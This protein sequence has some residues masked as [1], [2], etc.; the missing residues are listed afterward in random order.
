MKSTQALIHW[1]EVGAGARRIRLAALLLGTL[2]LS[3][4]VAWK[5]FHGATAETTML[6]ADVGRQ[7]ARGEGFTTQVNYPQAYRVLAERGPTFDARQPR[8]ELYQAPFYSLVIAGGLRL[9]PA[10]LR[11]S[12]F[13]HAPVP[14]D[15]FAGDYFLLALNLALFWVAAWQTYDLGRRLFEPRVGWLAA[16]G[17]LLSVPL[18]QQVVAINGVPLLMVLVLAVFRCWWQVEQAAETGAV[19]PWGWLAGLGVG[20]GLLFLTEYSAG[21]LVL[22]VLGYV[23]WRWRQGGCWAALGMVALA[24]LLVA[25]PWMARNLELTGNPVALA[26]QNLA[27]KA[28]DPTASPETVRA[29][30]SAQRPEVDLN[31]LGNKVLTS[32]QQNLVARLWGGGAMWFMAFFAV[33]WLYAFRTSATDRMRWLFTLSLLVLLI[34]QAAANSG[35]SER[36]PAIYLAPLIIIFGAGFFFVLVGSNPRLAAWPRVFATLLLALQ[37]LPL[38]HDVMEPRRLHFDYPPYYPGLFVGMR[39]ELTRRD[40]AQR[41]GVMADVPAGVAWY[42]DQ[43]VWAQPATLRDFYAITLDQS[44]GELLLTPHTL[45]RPF[46]S[47]LA[48]ARDDSLATNNVGLRRFGDWG[49]VYA[50]LA[51]GRLPDGF[52]LRVPQRLAENLYVLINPALPPPR[53]K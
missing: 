17:V 43:G 3:V 44:I 36:L 28:G 14:P 1:L 2:A 53:G 27:L 6:Q 37:A 42:G 38:L 11:A 21:A 10:R 39:E 34:V 47:E 50:G 25:G 48:S 19:R 26:A 15:G 52:P 35:E 40:A 49:Q 33:G 31:K 13:S 46:F 24:C 22:V 8:P 32:W 4:L 45:D 41:F 16:L 51:N 30:F 7:L 20:C 9:L 18:W 29:T 23:A 5:Q 12:L